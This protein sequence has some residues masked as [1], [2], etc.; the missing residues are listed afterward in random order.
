[1]NQIISLH[2]LMNEDIHPIN[3]IVDGLLSPG[4]YVLAGAPKSGKSWLTLW[5]C[6]CI[7]RGQPVWDMPVTQGGALYLCLEDNKQRLQNR[8]LDIFSEE[9]SPSPFLPV[10]FLLRYQGRR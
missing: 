7:A 3:F 4:L 6:L 9:Q 10:H 2:Q 1:M 5:L 8:L